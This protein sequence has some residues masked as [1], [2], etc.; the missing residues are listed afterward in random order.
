MDSSNFYPD[1]PI[2]AALLPGV[3]GVHT[4]K[5]LKGA[6]PCGDDMQ[7]LE[8]GSLR[9][10]VPKLQFKVLQPGFLG[11]TGGELKNTI[12]EKGSRELKP[13]EGYTVSSLGLMLVTGHPA[14]GVAV[15]LLGEE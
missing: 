15:L 13:S 9:Q 14:S 8:P 11:N 12:P 10:V 4:I 6:V 2:V 1:H 7:L 5:N 3:G